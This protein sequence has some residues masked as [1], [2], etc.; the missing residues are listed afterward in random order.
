MLA[1]VREFTQADICKLSLQF[2]AN[3]CAMF[4]VAELN[5]VASQGIVS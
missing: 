3:N 5:S 4:D 1:T 2:Q